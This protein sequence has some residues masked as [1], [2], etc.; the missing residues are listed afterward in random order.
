MLRRRTSGEESQACQEC[1][2]KVVSVEETAGAEAAQA[3]QQEFSRVGWKDVEGTVLRVD[4]PRERFA[5]H[6]YRVLCQT[7]F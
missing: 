6:V 7:V 4:A 3:R 5:V 2:L 1:A